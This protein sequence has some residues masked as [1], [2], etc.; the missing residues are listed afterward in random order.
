MGPRWADT[1]LILQ[2]GEKIIEGNFRLLQDVTQRRTLDRA[3]GRDG[4]F[5]LSARQLLLESDM[6]ATLANHGKRQTLQ[7]RHDPVVVFG[8]DPAH[9]V[10]PAKRAAVGGA[11]LDW[12]QWVHGRIAVVV[13]GF[14]KQPS[15]KVILQ[16]VHGSRGF[17]LKPS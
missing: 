3:M 14:T 17:L 8:W 2:R 13:A 4:N 5:D 16:W 9:G 15:K 12:I 1:P 10:P 7:G 11:R 6:T